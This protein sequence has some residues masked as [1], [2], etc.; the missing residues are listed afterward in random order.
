MIKRVVGLLILGL[1]V[2]LCYGGEAFNFVTSLSAPVGTFATLETAD[3][4][5]QST[6]SKVDFCSGLSD[7]GTIELLGSKAPWLSKITMEGYSELIGDDQL[8]EVHA[9]A[10]NLRRTGKIKGK[11]LLASQLTPTT[12]ST[13]ITTAQTLY[14]PKVNALVGV[15][16]GLRWLL[17]NDPQSRNARVSFTDTQT[18]VNANRDFHWTN[19]EQHDRIEGEPP[20]YV[21]DYE[22]QYL[23][24]SKTFV[25]G[26]GIGPGGDEPPILPPEQP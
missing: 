4:N 24:R 20:L 12:S 25:E 7:Q 3:P 15:T 10:I 18:G 2:G 21:E 1:S 26:G 17:P 19:Y 16:W 6:S 23:L 11:S 5:S 14:V 9:T 13:W 8:I 22:D